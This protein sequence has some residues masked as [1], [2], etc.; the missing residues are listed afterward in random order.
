MNRFCGWWRRLLTSRFLATATK[1]QRAAI[2]RD[3]KPIID[4]YNQL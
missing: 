1:E 2:K 3:L 4:I